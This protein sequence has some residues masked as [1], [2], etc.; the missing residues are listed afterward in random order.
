MSK[1]R[2]KEKD[3]Q[4]LYGKHAVKA[5]LKNPAR[6]IH[7][8]VLLKSSVEFQKEC[9]ATG[10][11][12]DEKFFATLFGRESVHQGCAVYV[13]RLRE[14]CLEEMVEDDSDMRPI[15]FLDQVTDP[16]NL[17]SI[18]RSA[19]V[20]GARAVVTTEDRG[21]G[22]TAAVAKAASGAL[23]AVPLIRV[24]NLVQS[25]KFLRK[26]GFWSIGLEE[27]SAK[28]LEEVSLNDKFILVV[29]GEGSGL[30]RLTRESCD[31]LA[32]LPS[33]SVFGTLNAAQAATVALYESLRQRC[34][35]N[36]R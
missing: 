36:N 4:W 27:K 13:K 12:V 20:F 22:L 26:H 1:N 34:L 3:L 7:R 14:H 35:A 11:I 23:E 2:N 30:R 19:A 5:A 32:K 33:W 28:T 9:G 25:I 31:F 21:P 6:E 16:Q 17:G 8:F 24:V 10:E 15:M 18:L 29:G